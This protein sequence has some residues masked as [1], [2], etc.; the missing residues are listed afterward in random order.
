[1]SVVGYKQTIRPCHGHVR[2]AP[3][4]RQS[5]LRSAFRPA[6]FA[7]PQEQTF[8]A[9][10]LYGRIATSAGAGDAGITIGT[11]PNYVSYT[12]QHAPG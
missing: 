4:S 10:P 7:S 3:R 1:M 2:F 11:D 5:S 12:R 8:L 9:V 6:P